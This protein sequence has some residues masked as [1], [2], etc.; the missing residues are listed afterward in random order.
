MGINPMPVF[1]AVLLILAFEGLLFGADLAERS[2]PSF[3]E[4]RTGGFFAALDAIL[5]VV[6]AVWGGVV[7]FFNLITVNVPGAPWYIRLPV[8]GIL[9][10]S[11]I[12]SIMEMVR[13][14]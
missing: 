9:G 2:F 13:G 4:P 8:G 6:K 14:K 5:A 12:W 10:G 11:L 3:E 7:F 1:A